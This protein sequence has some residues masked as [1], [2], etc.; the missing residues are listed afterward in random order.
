[1]ESIQESI[2]EFSQSKNFK[3]IKNINSDIDNLIDD[4]N[5]KINNLS[6]IEPKQVKKYNN[7][8]I[9]EL[10]KKMEKT[11]DIDKKIKIYQHILSII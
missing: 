8:S 10:F 7:N 2:E 4:Y 11:N 9:E 5:D 1:M 3:L 6:D